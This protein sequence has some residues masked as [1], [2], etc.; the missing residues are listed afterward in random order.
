MFAADR[1]EQTPLMNHVVLKF[2]QR[3]TPIGQAEVRGRLFGYAS[4]GLNLDC[5]DPRWSALALSV[6]DEGQTVVCKAMQIGVDCVDVD[7]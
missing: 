3:P 1:L 6:F 2:G 4:D 7:G 5:G